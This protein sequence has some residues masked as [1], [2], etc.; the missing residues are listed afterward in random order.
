MRAVVQHSALFHAKGVIG[1][2]LRREQQI[3][4]LDHIHIDGEVG[5]S[6]ELDGQGVARLLAQQLAPLVDLHAIPIHTA[7]FIGG[8]IDVDDGFG[9][10]DVAPSLL[11]GLPVEAGEHTAG[12][13]VIHIHLSQRLLHDDA[14]VVRTDN[15]LGQG[16]GIRL[17]PDRVIG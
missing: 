5:P 13:E 12:G 17:Q 14:R 2:D 10:V 8:L 15:H 11:G 3:R 4:V 7:S 6:Q 16:V 9:D 1:E